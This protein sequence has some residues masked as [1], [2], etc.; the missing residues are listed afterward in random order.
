MTVE[1][2][3]VRGSRQMLE[4]TDMVG[5]IVQPTSELTLVDVLTR[6]NEQNF[7]DHPSDE[8][9]PSECIY[10]L[11]R[12]TGTDKD[13][14]YNRIKFDQI[15]PH[16]DAVNNPIGKLPSAQGIADE[17]S[18]ELDL[19]I[20]H[21]NNG[22][23]LLG[24]EMV[25]DESDKRNFE[26]LVKS[27][28]LNEKNEG[29]G[30]GSHGV[31]KSVYWQWSKHGIVLF[32]SRLSEPY[33]DEGKYSGK[34]APTALTRR[35]IGTGRLQVPH[36]VDDI[37]YGK[38]GMLGALYTD[39]GD[40]EP[41][42]LYDEDADEIAAELGLEV[43]NED[44]PGTTIVIV[45]FQY[46]QRPDLDMLTIAE[47]GYDED[48]NGQNVILPSFLEASQK[49][50][51][52][53]KLSQCLETSVIDLNGDTHPWDPENHK[54]YK[55]LEWLN[56]T[57][58]DEAIGQPAAEPINH[59]VKSTTYKRIELD[60]HIPR[61]Y[62]GN[63]A[64]NVLKSKAVLG[65]VIIDDLANELPYNPS[66]GT[67][68]WGT[69]ACIRHKGMVVTYKPFIPNPPK[70][71][72]GILLVG[73]SVKLFDKQLREGGTLN[74]DVQSLAE[75]M[76]K[77]S[78]PAVHDDWLHTNFSSYVRTN[79]KVSRTHAAVANAGSERIKQFTRNVK[80]AIQNALGVIKP[81]EA[82]SDAKW[83]ELS[84]ELNF[85]SNNAETGGRMISITNQDVSKPEANQA[86]LSFKVNV[87]AKESEGWSEGA[88][89]W[90][91][92]ITPK[93]RWPNGKIV[94]LETELS[95][96]DFN[97][98]MDKDNHETWRTK[99]KVNYAAQL[100][101]W[102]KVS[103]TQARD[104]KIDEWDGGLNGLTKAELLQGKAIK[105]SFVNLPIDL[106]GYE[107]AM[108]E[109]IIEADEVVEE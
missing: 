75:E 37:M 35:F 3:F 5:K 85:G 47:E 50:W 66:L 46:P 19:L 56:T 80:K 27:Y 4:H 109:I 45:G 103:T 61:D 29:G 25:T 32:Y 57:E 30:G 11:R 22:V 73:D 74:D 59:E 51:F 49:G 83:A 105:L 92:S 82:E 98:L 88:T 78:E 26:A 44:N 67:D 6:E 90:K 14:F 43:R 16:L 63:P 53:G 33:N 12:L 68:E 64:N 91:L 55:L 20:I 54:R 13:N 107:T 52:P 96:L 79:S 36:Q 31:G 94:N 41:I 18:D 58:T 93:L 101:Q 81:P 9:E 28:G 15:Q 62:P 48:E 42:C 10:E 108:L 106:T 1:W 21:H 86:L 2:K 39:E 76:M 40:E 72:Q 95:I 7:V 34:D 17:I 102:K 60:L 23:G 89:H 104:M 38:I 97:E 24:A 65:L 84:K 87:P 99:V 69:T 77:F 8:G 70:Y 71:Y 100:V